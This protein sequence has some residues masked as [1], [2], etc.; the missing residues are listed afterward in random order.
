VPTIT[1]RAGFSDNA[2]REP[3]DLPWRYESDPRLLTCGL[4]TAMA[5]MSHRT[6]MVSP[7]GST[8]RLRL[9]LIATLG[10]Q[11]GSGPAR[12]RLR[13]FSRVGPAPDHRASPQL[14]RSPGP[15]DRQLVPQVA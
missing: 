14:R 8:A 2:T 15:D 6:S 4:E 10:S 11:P 5:R 12:E 9:F 13:G 7:A 1:R 3:T